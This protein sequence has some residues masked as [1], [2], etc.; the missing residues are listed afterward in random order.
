MLFFGLSDE[1]SRQFL[2]MQPL[3]NTK[4][5]KNKSTNQ[6]SRHKF[7][8]FFMYKNNIHSL[9]CS[10]KTFIIW[11]RISR[12][13]RNCLQINYTIREKSTKKEKG[14]IWVSTTS[15]YPTIAHP[16][17]HEESNKKKKELDLSWETNLFF[18]FV[19]HACHYWDFLCRQF[20][21]E[22]ELLSINLP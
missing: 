14:N 17:F 10:K 13:H 16:P 1:A 21:L 19:C 5:F 7:K 9:M 11:K 22:Y 12:C 4:F 15:S 3:K 20:R 8:K 2:P 18:I 6:N